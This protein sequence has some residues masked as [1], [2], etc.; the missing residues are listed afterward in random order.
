M[1]WKVVVIGKPALVYA[2]AGIA[3]Y[4]SRLKHYAPVELLHLKDA[5]S[6]EGNARRLLA[7]SEGCLRLVLDERG[8][9]LTTGQLVDWVQERTMDGVVK[10]V[11]VLIGGADG[12]SDET[13]AQADMVLN[14]SKL[15]LQ[16]ELALL[17]FLEQLYR[18]HT[19]MRGEP[20]HR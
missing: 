3:D 5:G 15:T 9:S 7:A 13:R 12:H 19:V 1:K 10:Q 11:A 2:R 18:V 16:H 6:V 20:Y 14:L 17:V 8:K 4:V